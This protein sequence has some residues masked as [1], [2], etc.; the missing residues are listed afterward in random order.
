MEGGGGRC[1]VV[2]L[3][4]KLPFPDPKISGLGAF[5]STYPLFIGSMITICQYSFTYYVIGNIV[6]IYLIRK[7]KQ[8]RLIISHVVAFHVCTVLPMHIRSHHIP[9]SRPNEPR[10]YRV[11]SGYC[12]YMVLNCKILTRLTQQDFRRYPESVFRIFL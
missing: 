2:G 5:Y 3:A 11:S 12:G 8:S 6:G 7:Y 10:V 1:W 4:L 9:H